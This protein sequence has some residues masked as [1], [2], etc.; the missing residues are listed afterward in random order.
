MTLTIAAPTEATTAPAFL[1]LEEL[2]ARWSCA[3]KTLRNRMSA[4][5]PMPTP[6][7]L[8]GGVRFAL[9]DVEQFESNQKGA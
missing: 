4:R 7:R 8:P 9:A 1:R 3:P 5:Q 2:A 6:T